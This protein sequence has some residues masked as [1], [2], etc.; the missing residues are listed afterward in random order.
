MGIDDPIFA[1]IGS[2]V[3]RSTLAGTA[4]DASAL[5]WYTRR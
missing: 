4:E 5:R 2:H 1:R 3:A